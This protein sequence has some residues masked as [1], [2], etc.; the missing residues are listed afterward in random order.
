MGRPR[1]GAAASRKSGAL[2]TNKGKAKSTVPVLDVGYN[3]SI[4]RYEIF[5]EE[6]P[7]LPKGYVA[8][9]SEIEATAIVWRL[10]FS[11]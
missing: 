6:R 4:N 3:D 10:K 2:A 9:E 1:K 5:S 7:K 11:A 8:Y